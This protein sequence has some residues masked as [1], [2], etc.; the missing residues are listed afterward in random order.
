MGMWTQMPRTGMMDIKVKQPKLLNIRGLEFEIADME[1][2]KNGVYIWI[3]NGI[4]IR[5]KNNE[6]KKISEWFEKVYNW[7]KCE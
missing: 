5:I 3:G 2:D 6:L 1:H 7:N 4:E